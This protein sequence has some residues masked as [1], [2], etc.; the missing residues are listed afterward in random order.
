MNMKMMCQNEVRI[1]TSLDARTRLMSRCFRPPT[2]LRQ[3]HTDLV[4]ADALSTAALA[5]LAIVVWRSLLPR[6]IYVGASTLCGPLLRWSAVTSLWGGSRA[7]LDPHALASTLCSH[8][9]TSAFFLYSP[10]PP[11]RCGLE[12]QP[13]EEA[14][15]RTTS[16]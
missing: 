8:L 5:A 4:G 2:F 12:A 6:P 9:R 10:L 16:L 1:Q 11:L 3:P 13:T 14:W 7:A 15:E